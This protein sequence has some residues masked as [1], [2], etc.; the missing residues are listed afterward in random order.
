MI[1]RNYVFAGR[2]GGRGRWHGRGGARGRSG[3]QELRTN[4]L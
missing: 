4:G 3:D 2:G 1:I